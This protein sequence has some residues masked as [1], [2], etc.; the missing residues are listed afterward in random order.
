MR[1][2]STISN[3]DMI[4]TE[5]T[6]V[7]PA[8]Y[9]PEPEHGWC[10]YFQKADLARQLGDWDE[11]A[12]LGDTAFKLDDHPNDPIERF[13]FVEGYAHVGD[14]DRAVKYSRESYRVSKEYVGPILCQLWER[15]EAETDQSPERSDALSEIRNMLACNQ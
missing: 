10:Y 14:W 2:A 1:E 15:I 4:L 5:Q 3:A 9:Y 12:K 6:S 13:V 11:V 8:I 7:M